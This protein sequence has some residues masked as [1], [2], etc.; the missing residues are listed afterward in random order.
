MQSLQTALWVAGLY[1]A[2]QFVESNFITTFIQQKLIN[3]P[4]ALI[5]IAQLFMGATIGGWGVVLATPVTLIVIIVVQ[6]LYIKTRSK[7]SA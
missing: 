2:V 5:L 3:M 4:P 6:E 1:I 7:Q